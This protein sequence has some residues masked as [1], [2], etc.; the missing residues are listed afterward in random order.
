[1]K[2]IYLVL[3]L[4]STGPLFSQSKD[5][6]EMINEGTYTVQEIQAAAEAHFENKDKGRGSG[7]KQY[8]R[9]EYQALRS[10]KDNGVLRSNKFYY[11]ELERYNNYINQNSVNFSITNSTCNKIPSCTS[12]CRFKYRTVIRSPKIN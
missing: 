10:I 4:L 1:M 12:I 8:K 7:Y 2:K 6:S 5:Y 11:N 3:L 9:W